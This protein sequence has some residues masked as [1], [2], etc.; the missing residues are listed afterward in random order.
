MNDNANNMSLQDKD[1]MADLL[2]SEK[3]LCATY[4]TSVIEAATP[5]IR[6]EL[7]TIFS[8]QLDI[9]NSIFTVLNQN[10]WYPVDAADPAKVSVA[11][12]TLSQSM[13]Q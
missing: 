4:N 3:H 1:L 8:E 12:N 6:S 7:K 2:G 13:P 11:K 10:G 5:N 9:Q